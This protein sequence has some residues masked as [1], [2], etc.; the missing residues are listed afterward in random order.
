MGEVKR[1]LA[2]NKEKILLSGIQVRR[3]L[4]GCVVHPMASVF[5]GWKQLICS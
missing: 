4:A 2:D 3:K 5:T 1:V